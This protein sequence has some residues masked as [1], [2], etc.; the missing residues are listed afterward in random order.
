[1]AEILYGKLV[2]ES[3]YDVVGQRVSKLASSGERCTIASVRIGDNPDDI[4]YERSISKACENHGIGFVSNVL[5]SDVGT[6]DV[7]AEIDR[8]NDD[9]SIS[10][11]IVFH[12]MP[13]HIASQSVCN[14]ISPEKDIDC[15]SDAA[16][17]DVILGKDGAFA[18][19]TAE[20]VI[21]VCDYYGIEISGANVVVVGRS[22]VIGKPAGMLALNRNATVTFC[23]SNT[24]GL[25]SITRS[26]DIVV[27]A[28]GKPNYFDSD[29]FCEG[30]VVVDVGMNVDEGGSL[31]G[32][33][34]FDSAA[35][36]V[37]AITPVPGGIGAIT[38]SILLEHATRQAMT[39]A[40]ENANLYS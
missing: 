36:I 8:I 37:S 9:D 25:P 26:A 1:M 4:A 19:A 3:V 13:K 16:L 23:H 40:G 31:C 21:K 2:A 35:N 5:P 30:Q 24:R 10:G 39:K 28:V 17:G 12:P 20:A 18:P 15:T 29:Y 34:D 27:C 7:L 32:D 14:A 22:R 6:D 33:A 11:C 38:T